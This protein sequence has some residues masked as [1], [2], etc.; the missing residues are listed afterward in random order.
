MINETCPDCGDPIPTSAPQGLCS[1]CLLMAGLQQ[2]D[3]GQTVPLGE[4]SNSD[5]AA[6]TT[7]AYFGDYQ[8]IS[9]IARGGM[10]VVYKA[11][12]VNLNRDVAL[13]MILAGA[14]ANV[15]DITR[16]RTEAEAAANLKHPNIVAIHE[17]G[18]HDGQ[19]Y[20]ALARPATC[21]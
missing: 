8:L 18:E 5:V 4:E 1:Y 10:G 2:A 12:Q 19:P 15:A 16:F 20:L 6:G 14:L 3:P 17:V 13:K 9:E 11:R 21:V 7:V